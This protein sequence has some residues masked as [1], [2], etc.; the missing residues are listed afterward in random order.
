MRKFKF[1]IWDKIGKK[2]YFVDHGDIMRDGDEFEWSPWV[3]V[4]KN[5]RVED[6]IFMQYTGLN[7]KNGKEIYDGDLVRVPTM[8]C[9]E[10]DYGL[11]DLFEVIWSMKYGAWCGYS[12]EWIES[13]TDDCIISYEFDDND[14]EVIG[15]IY[16][17]PDLL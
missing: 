6:Y 10:D 7:D 14:M 11:Y 12:K 15:N 13:G 3:F 5:P 1:R 16:E 17:N 8:S 4:V 2:M 9:A